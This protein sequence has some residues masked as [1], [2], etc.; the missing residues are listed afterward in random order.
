MVLSGLVTL[1]A[2]VIIALGWPINSL[3]VLGMFL[4]IDLV[5][6]G[7]ATIALGLAL[8]RGVPQA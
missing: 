3:W 2:G 1:L 4:A 5:F 6:Q 7:W 8:K